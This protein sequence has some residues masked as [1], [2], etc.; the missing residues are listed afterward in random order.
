[1]D[2]GR[3]NGNYYLGLRVY[4]TLYKYTPI[5]YLNPV[6]ALDNNPSFTGHIRP[7]LR[8]SLWD[9]IRLYRGY[10]GDSGKEMELLLRAF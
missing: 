10:I 3:Y 4:I 6:Q 1:M 2:D 8:T 5:S 9:Y 7:S